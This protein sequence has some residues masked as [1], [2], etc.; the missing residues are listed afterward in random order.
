MVVPQMTFASSW[1]C[2]WMRLAASLISL[3]RMSGPPAK[4]M[5]TPMAPM[6]EMSSSSGEL[7]ACSA[8]RSARPCPLAQ[9][10][11]MSA[12][13]MFVM[14]VRTSAKSTLTMPCWMMRS[15]IPLTAW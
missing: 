15:L 7:I 8:A 9:P 4:L 14:M 6:T 1:A 10:V 3:R 13:P 2:S 5:S 12:R 11:P